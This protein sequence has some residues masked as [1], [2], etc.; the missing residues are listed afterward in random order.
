M[1]DFIISTENTTDL[2]QSFLDE[3]NIGLMFLP[4]TLDGITYDMNSQLPEKTFYDK[5]RNGSMPTTSQINPTE[6][7]N[8]FKKLIDTYHCDILH[9]AFSSGLSG[10]YNNTRLAAEELMEEGIPYKIIVIDSLCASMGEGLF[11]Y[12][13]VK[14]KEQGFSIEDTAKWLE[15]HKMNFAHNFTVDDLN[16]LYRGGRV[17]KTAAVLGTI[18]NIK[19]ML[20][21]DE[22]GHL[23][24]VNKVRGRKKSLIA[25]V[26][27]M[28]A[29]IGSWR[30]KND[31]IFI[32]HGDSL[33]DAEFVQKLIEE[34]FGYKSF[35][36]NTIGATIGAH[37]GPGTVALFYMGDYR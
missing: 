1:S 6:A 28:E 13:A 36:L 10:T 7:R 5:V 26:D 9:I 17:S 19:P 34:R 21:V 11:V 8:D 16:H 4:Y 37:S 12:K 31:M 20:H 22:E 18:V 27:S 2:P 29:Q 15:D 23:V 35:L 14:L 3:H 24:V 25:L 30:D 33:E 32:S